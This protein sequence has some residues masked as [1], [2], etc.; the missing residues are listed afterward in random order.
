MSGVS[1][2]EPCTFFF[3]TGS[4]TRIRLGWL[5]REL[6]GSTYVCLLCAGMTRHATAASLFTCI[7]GVKCR[8]SC[9]RG[10]FVTG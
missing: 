7:V 10:K 4:L 9:F 5:P 6:Q 1:P 8:A 2:Q 3:E